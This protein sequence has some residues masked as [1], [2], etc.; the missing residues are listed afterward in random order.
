MLLYRKGILTL[1]QLNYGLLKPLCRNVLISFIRLCGIFYL[2]M[3]AME[4][5][6]RL[7]RNTIQLN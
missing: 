4:K 6:I 5:F 2:I 7:S 3:N 1:F